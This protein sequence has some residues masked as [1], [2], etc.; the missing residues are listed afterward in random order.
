[1][2]LNNN[3]KNMKK[4]KGRIGKSKTKDNITCKDIN[5]KIQMRKTI[6]KKKVVLK[7]QLITMNGTAPTISP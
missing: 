1:M 4:T 7:H 3:K 5:K 2:Q 6:T